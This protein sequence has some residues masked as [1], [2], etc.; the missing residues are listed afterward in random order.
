ML[1][2]VDEAALPATKSLRESGGMH[3]SFFGWA[4]L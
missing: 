2:L 3:L 1:L 4:D